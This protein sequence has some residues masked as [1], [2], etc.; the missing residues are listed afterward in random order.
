MNEILL[1]ATNLLMD[2]EGMRIVGV[3]GGRGLVYL[4]CRRENYLYVNSVWYD[5]YVLLTYYHPLSRPLL[6]SYHMHAVCVVSV[7]G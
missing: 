6:L 4:R 7:S 5:V 2:G 3:I 1:F